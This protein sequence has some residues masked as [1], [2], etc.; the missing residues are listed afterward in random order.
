[1][2]F[3]PSAFVFLAVLTA[4]LSTRATLGIG[5]RGPSS[6]SRPSCPSQALQPDAPAPHRALIDRY[7]VTCHSDRVKTV[8]LTLEKRD[9][10]RAPEDA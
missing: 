6:P 10:S 8:G 7:C 3:R 5:G 1:M 4:V 9:L 2:K